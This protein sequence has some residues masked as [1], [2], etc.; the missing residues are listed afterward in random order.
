MQT[1]FREDK[2]KLSFEQDSLYALAEAVKLR[3]E[4]LEKV[5][6]HQ[7]EQYTYRVRLGDFL[8][9]RDL[10]K[11][12]ELLDKKFAY[13]LF[14]DQKQVRL[15]LPISFVFLLHTQL[16]QATIDSFLQF[17]IDQPDK[18]IKSHPRQDRLH[19]R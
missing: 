4:T 7:Y 16:N 12:Q 6:D 8:I 13:M 17:A 9:L 5:I 15:S 3:A 10:M 18:V 11:V 19:L 2:L 14:R 1:T